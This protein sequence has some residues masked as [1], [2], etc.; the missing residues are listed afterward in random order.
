MSLSIRGVLIG[1]S[2]ADTHFC[3]SMVHRYIK[4]RIGHS[5]DRVEAGAE[6]LS[7]QSYGLLRVSLDTPDGPKLITP[8]NVS[9]IPTFSRVW[10]LLIYL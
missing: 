2:G 7:M 6:S 1:D 10:Q 4:Q 8:N 3:N 5:D 9:C